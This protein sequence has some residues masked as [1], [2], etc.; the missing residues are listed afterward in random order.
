MCPIGNSIFRPT[1][2]KICQK[3]NFNPR[4]PLGASICG[5]CCYETLTETSLDEDVRSSNQKFWKGVA[6]LG[7]SIC[8]EC[9][10]EK[11]HRSQ[12][13]L[14]LHQVKIWYEKSFK[15]FA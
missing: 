3:K 1:M 2:K 9:C 8:K 7:A 6:P 15:D 5:E 12:A 4:T 14:K 10:S 13:Q 11:N